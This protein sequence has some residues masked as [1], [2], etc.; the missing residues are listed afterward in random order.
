[1]KVVSVLL[2]LLIGLPLL[3][4]STSTSSSSVA[5]AAT[6]SPFVEG[7]KTLLA[8]D[9]P[10]IFKNLLKVRASKVCTSSLHLTAIPPSLSLSLSLS[11][12]FFFFLSFSLSLCPSVHPSI[13]PSICDTSFHKITLTGYGTLRRK[14]SLQVTTK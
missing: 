8:G 12:F 9:K 13:H 11:L 4:V 3:L 1:M 5:T 6:P 14:M 10:I 2:S 7:T